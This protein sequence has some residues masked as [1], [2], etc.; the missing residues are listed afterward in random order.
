MPEYK[1]TMRYNPET[2]VVEQTKVERKPSTT[3]WVRGDVTFIVR[4]ETLQTLLRFA[5]EDKLDVSDKIQRG[6]AINTY[7]RAALS[8]FV[9]I[10]QTRQTVAKAASAV[11]PEVKPEATKQTAQ[12]AVKIAPPAQPAK[13]QQPVAAAR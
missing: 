7:I 12:P 13:L 1:T 6:K 9:K 5:R 8:E 11:K 4:D 2:G 3:G 10:R